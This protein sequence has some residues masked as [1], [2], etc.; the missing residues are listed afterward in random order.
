MQMKRIYGMTLMVAAMLLMVTACNRNKDNATAALTEDTD[1]IEEQARMDYV[2]DEMDNFANEAAELGSVQLKGGVMLGNCATVTRDTVSVPHTVEIDFGTTNCQCADGRFRRGKVI[3]AYMGNYK[4][5]GFYRNI[6]FSGY[7]VN[8]NEVLGGR[9][10]TNMGKNSNGDVYYNV[11]INGM[12]VLN[13]TGDTMSH[14][15]TRTRTWLAGY[16]TKQ[17]SDDEYMITGS[18]SFVRATG[19]SATVNI[20]SPL[21]IAMNCNWI[22]QGTVQITPKGASHSRVL[23]YGNGSCDDKAAITMNSKTKNITL[24]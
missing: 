2:F 6:S 21:V 4:D 12:M 1:D 19:K 11:S 20:T 24:R 22:K 9:T 5:S 8:D 16:S 14:T 23:D 10:I 13:K 18:G 17:L 7:H 3:V 15:A